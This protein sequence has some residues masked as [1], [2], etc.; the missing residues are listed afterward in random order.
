MEK[1]KGEKERR[2]ENDREEKRERGGLKKWRQ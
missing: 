1:E 2:R